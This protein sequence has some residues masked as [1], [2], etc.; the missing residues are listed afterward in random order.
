MF[1]NRFRAV[2]QDL[3]WSIFAELWDDLFLSARAWRVQWP[4]A[5]VYLNIN[6]TVHRNILMQ[7]PVVVVHCKSGNL[8]VTLESCCRIASRA[9]Y[10]RSSTPSVS[11]DS[12]DTLVCSVAKCSHTAT[13]VAAISVWSTVIWA[14][15]RRISVRVVAASSGR[16]RSPATWST[17][18]R[19]S[20]TPAHPRP[21]RRRQ[22]RNLWRL[23]V[24]PTLLRR[25]LSPS[26]RH[27]HHDS[28]LHF[29]PLV[30]PLEASRRRDSP[31]QNS[32][33]T[34]W[35]LPLSPASTSLPSPST[36]RLRPWWQPRTTRVLSAH[37]LL[38]ARTISRRRQLPSMLWRL[39]LPSSLLASVTCP[40]NLL[41][42][43]SR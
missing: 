21:P 15:R 34:D 9:S 18:H 20:K 23:L 25:P 31:F 1:F 10:F 5:T 7:L 29:L 8:N 4:S 39:Q 14:S 41:I 3:I 2:L 19:P 42:I 26:P 35:L 13:P 16:V 27:P 6:R 22:A 17:A 24:E 12:R 30:S 37:Q 11:T 38:W 36:T 28:C 32:P 40:H 43:K 33:P